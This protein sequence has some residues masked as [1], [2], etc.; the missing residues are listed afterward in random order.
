MA[1]FPIIAMIKLPIKFSL[2]I[3]NF[4]FEE[5]FSFPS[6][7]IIPMNTMERHDTP[8]RNKNVEYARF[9]FILSIIRSVKL[10]ASSSTQAAIA[11]LKY[12]LTPK[13]LALRPTP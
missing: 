12:G 4:K 8:A 1:N 13:S 5:T 11:K 7:K 9:L 3:L 2:K 6:L 10:Q